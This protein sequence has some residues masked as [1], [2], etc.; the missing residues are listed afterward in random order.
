[1]HYLCPV[2]LP[3]SNISLPMIPKIF[4]KFAPAERNIR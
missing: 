3:F 1:M 4:T 2:K